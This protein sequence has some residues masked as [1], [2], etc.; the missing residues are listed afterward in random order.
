MP[1]LLRRD[2]SAVSEVVGY[3]LSFAISAVFLMIALSAFNTARSNSDHVVTGAELKSIA[4]RIAARVVEAGVV[5]Q[6]FP[7][8][9]YNLT[10]ALPRDLNGH[11][12]TVVATDTTIT[13]TTNDVSLTASSTTF[14]LDAVAGIEVTGTWISAHERL[15]VTYS[16]Q[17]GDVRR[18]HIHEG[19]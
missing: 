8:A 19:S 13:V 6:E 17:P 11:P 18:I 16:P 5:S 2:D 7:N 9:T 3:I 10:L 1:R 14:R 4:D 12:Y 15:V